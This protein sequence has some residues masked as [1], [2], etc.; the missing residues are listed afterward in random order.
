MCRAHCERRLIAGTGNFQEV[1]RSKE[2]AQVL[3]AAVYILLNLY[4]SDHRSP[5]ETF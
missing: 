5:P 4:I 3:D 1:M 2:H